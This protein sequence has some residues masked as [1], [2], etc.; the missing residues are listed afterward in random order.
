MQWCILKALQLKKAHLHTGIW[1]CNLHPIC[2]LL[3]WMSIL[4]SAFSIF[5]RDVKTFSSLLRYA[6]SF[7]GQLN[8]DRG[9]QKAQQTRNGRLMNP[10]MSQPWSNGCAFVLHIRCC[11]LP[12][13]TCSPF[14]ISSAL[15]GDVSCF[16]LFLQI[17]SWMCT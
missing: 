7:L 2:H 17:R 16:A 8:F 5:L 9:W 6:N 3:A 12:I 4:L 15:A 14:P 11:G 13:V 10:D 1:T